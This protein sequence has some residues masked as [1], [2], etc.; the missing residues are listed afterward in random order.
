MEKFGIEC[1]KLMAKETKE[2]LKESPGFFVASF[3]A[4]AVSEQEELRR[5]LKEIDVS[6]FVVKNRIAKRAFKEL[7]QEAVAALLQGPAAITLGGCDSISISKALV[8]FAGKHENFKILG[9]YLDEQVLDLS[10]VKTLASIPSKEVLLAQIV[11]G[12][13]SPIQGLVT[14]LSAM[15]KKFVIV[16]DKIREKK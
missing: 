1:K 7:K 15:I 9:A 14:S 4:M 5:K 2:R 11:G 8:N 12:F 10:S 6:L 13:K 16:I 3:K